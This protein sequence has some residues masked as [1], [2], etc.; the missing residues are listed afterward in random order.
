MRK[1]LWVK[2]RWNDGDTTFPW[3]SPPVDSLVA[4]D[5]EWPFEM[6][7]PGGKTMHFTESDE[8]DAF[9]RLVAPPAQGWYDMGYVDEDGD[10][11]WVG[12]RH[13]VDG[14]RVLV[15]RPVTREEAG[16]RILREFDLIPEVG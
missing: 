11:W 4:K 7:S 14:G 8:L 6:P 5:A 9:V 15:A 1:G 10:W 13:A 16:D 2:R 3:Q 12:L